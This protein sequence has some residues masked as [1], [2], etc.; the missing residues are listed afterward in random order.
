ML[1]IGT[2]CFVTAQFNNQLPRRRADMVERKMARKRAP[3]H[4]KRDS[5]GRFASANRAADLRLSKSSGSKQAKN[6]ENMVE[7]NEIDEE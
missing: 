6:D 4:V 2:V 5:E 3:T 7:H 1:R